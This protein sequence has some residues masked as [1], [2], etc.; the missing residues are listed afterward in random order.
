VIFAKLALLSF[1]YE[2]DV[3][4]DGFDTLGLDLLAAKIN[5]EE[6]ELMTVLAFLIDMGLVSVN[7]NGTYHI[8]MVKSCID[9]T[10]AALKN[11]NSV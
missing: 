8:P 2:G 1:P 10:N 7:E 5:Q 6:E 11:N 3:I 4:I 9:R